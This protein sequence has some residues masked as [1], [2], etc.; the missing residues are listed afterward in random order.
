M[1]G[2]SDPEAPKAESAAVS[3]LTVEDHAATR[4]A[5]LALLGSAFPHCK[6]LA[7]DSAER[8]LELCR[9]A[10]PSLIIMDVALPG[11]NGIEATGLIRQMHPAALIVMYSNSDMAIYREQAASAG[12]AAFISKSGTARELIPTVARMLPAAR[13]V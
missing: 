2:A 6:L 5:V 10:Q 4:E 1:S 13:K 12:A 7:A 9:S 8:A 11:M 3:I